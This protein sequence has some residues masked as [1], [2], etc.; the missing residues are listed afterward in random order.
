MSMDENCRYISK[1]GTET[2]HTMVFSQ[3]KNSENNKNN[4]GKCGQ[5]NSGSGQTN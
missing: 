2:G 5:S 4:L 3:N 1:M